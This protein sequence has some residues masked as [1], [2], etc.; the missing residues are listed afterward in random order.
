MT[1]TDN[2]ARLAATIEAIGPL[3][4]AF[5]GGVDSAL[6]AVA[7]NRVLGDDAMAVTADSASL[8]D[9]ELDHCRSLAE[10]HGLAWRAVVTDELTD[11]RYRANDGDRCFWCKSALMDQL[12][13]LAEARGA[14]VALGVNLDDLGDHRPG[15]EAAA[16][17]GARF[18]LVEAGLDK[19]AIRA[20]AQQWG[21]EVWDRPAMPCL[22]SR[23][24][25]GTA[26]SVDLLSRV[27]RAEAAIRRLGFADVRVRHYDDTARIEV[28]AAD[29]AAVVERADE[30]VAGVSAAGYRYVTLDLAGL[31]S[32]NLNGALALHES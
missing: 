13:P 17:R 11:P 31:R 20:M 25:Y 22:S 32:G 12:Q 5:S 21:L 14:T 2:E 8:A 26:V 3:V 9:G 10:R 27:D 24:P 4:V 1:E 19:A 6:L 30:I 29:L 28:P 16:E 23:L 18:P 15:Q 7:A